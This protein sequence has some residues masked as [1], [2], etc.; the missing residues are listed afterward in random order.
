MF[1]IFYIPTIIDL[2]YQYSDV[3]VGADAV[4]TN[5][6]IG[7]EPLRVWWGIVDNVPLAIV[8]AAVFPIVVLIFHT[9]IIKDDSQYRLSWQIYLI[10]L[11]MWSVLY[12]KGSREWHGNFVWGYICGLFLIFM[13]SVIVLIKDSVE[14]LE[15]DMAFRQLVAILFQW[16]IFVMHV[17]LGLKYFYL[18]LVYGTD[19]F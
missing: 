6:G 4:D 1:G 7:I 19:Y 12:E 15:N 10:S 11:L 5:R 8:L 17:L 18:L 14:Y 2:L 9:K 3:F 16:L 13:C